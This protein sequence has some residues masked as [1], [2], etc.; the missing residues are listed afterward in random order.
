MNLKQLITIWT[1]DLLEWLTSKF[2][3]ITIDTSDL[4]KEVNATTN[5]QA[6]LSAIE[7]AK[8][9]LQGND[10]TATLAALKTAIAAIDV[11]DLAKEATLGDVKSVLEY[12][13]QGG[14][15]E[16][17]AIAKQG[18]NQDATLS[19]VQSGVQALAPVAQAAEAY[20]VGKKQLAQNITSKGV[21]ASATETLPELA[22]KVNS[23]SQESYTIDGG[24][25]YAKQLF[26][27]FDT[28]KYWNLYDVLT[29][30]LSD[31]RLVS[32]GGILLA[33]YSRGYD[34]LALTGAGAG[35]AYVISDKDENGQFKMYTEDTTHVWATE[36]DGYGN[37]W[38]AYC[39]NDEY[40]DFQITD[41]NTSP[42]SIF[43]GRKVGIISL[44]T[45]ARTT[46]VVV[47]DGNELLTFSSGAHISTWNQ[48]GTLIIKR[49]P[50]N[51]IILHKANILS[52]YIAIDDASEE[53]SYS[54]NAAFSYVSIDTL[55]LDIKSTCSIGFVNGNITNLIVAAKNFVYKN[56]GFLIA[57]NVQNLTLVG[58]ENWSG[59]LRSA[60][61]NGA[62]SKLTLLYS[63]NDKSKNV[64][65]SGNMN[66]A[67][68]VELK[69]GWCKNLSLT[70]FP[71]L[72]EV[73]I[74]SHILQKLKQDEAGCGSGITITFGS[75]N[76]AKLTSEESQ[77]LL[78]SL[79]G[80][81]GYTFA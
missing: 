61:G 49:V 47:P 3:S 20:N 80:I 7:Q 35:G 38:G 66:S 50:Q 78:A 63:T 55:I 23:I 31:G 36:F 70:V 64:Y 24:E 71:N 1:H 81:Y 28:P 79:R 65:F 10:Q 58:I 44:L 15:P 46:Q 62:A 9:A 25:M 14:M 43:I 72:T 41:T 59:S 42:Y 26:G 18:T 48:N 17:A 6:V 30:L 76:L 8:I 69:D 11:S 29:N 39:F 77:E 52:M 51:T 68:D 34:S 73:N 19:K 21:E 57:S 53:V 74:Y 33:E 13:E 16:I 56:Y 12:I 45:N 75:T 37:R 27:S 32:Y 54:N 4:A 22:E 60:G 2:D 40:H 67:T 5:K